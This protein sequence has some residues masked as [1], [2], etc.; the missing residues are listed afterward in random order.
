M[1]AG[2]RPIDLWVD[3]IRNVCERFESELAAIGDENNRYN[4]LTK[5]NVI[6]QAHNIC[7]SAIT[8]DAWH[9]GYTLSVHGVVTAFTMAGCRSSASPFPHCRISGNTRPEK[10]MYAT[11]PDKKPITCCAGCFDLLSCRQAH[12]LLLPDEKAEA[13]KLMRKTMVWCQQS[14]AG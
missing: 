13:R 8:Q 9:K 3:Q 5:P 4:R 2:T 14:C 6:A 7:R 11:I 10:A 1:P 12:I